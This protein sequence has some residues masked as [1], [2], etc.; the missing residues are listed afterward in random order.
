MKNGLSLG[1]SVERRAAPSSRVERRARGATPG[2]RLLKLS[3]T[4]RLRSRFSLSKVETFPPGKR[5]SLSQGF[6]QDGPERE[7]EL[8]GVRVWG[9]GNSGWAGLTAVGLVLSVSAVVL[10]V[11]AQVERDALLLPRALELSRQADVRLWKN[12]RNQEV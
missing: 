12:E 10:A 5:L 1:I 9:R 3:W 7:G 11:A 8:E 2:A 4:R 6:G